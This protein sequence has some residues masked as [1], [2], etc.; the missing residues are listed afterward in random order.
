M[1]DLKNSYANRNLLLQV[2]TVSLMVHYGFIPEYFPWQFVTTLFTSVFLI[3]KPTNLFLPVISVIVTLADYIF[4]YPELS[5]HAVIQFF[6]CLGI[7]L[8]VVRSVL[9]FKTSFYTAEQKTAL[10]RL[11]VFLIYFFSGFHKLNYGFLDWDQSCV[12]ELN[13]QITYF[14]GVGEATLPKWIVRIMQLATLFVELIVPFGLLWRRT[15]KLSV[16]LLF[17]LHAYLFIAGF[18]H[19]A[20]VS[21]VLLPAC[22]IDFR[23]VAPLQTFK[24]KLRSYVFIA[25]LA[26]LV[27]FFGCHFFG[28]RYSADKLSVFFFICC[29]IYFIAFITAVDLFRNY[30]PAAFSYKKILDLKVLF[31]VLFIFLWGMEPYYGLSNR[32]NMSM[33]SNLITMKGRDNHLLMKSKYTKLIP[34]EE[35]CLQLLEV[36]PNLIRCFGRDYRY[37]YYPVITF[38][39]RTNECLRTIQE[40]VYVKFIYKSD[41]IS[42]SDLRKSV[43]SAS[44]WYDRYFYYRPTPVKGYGICVW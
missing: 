43:W 23:S 32:A 8:L 1:A 4:A 17:V 31:P 9:N 26:S 22:L 38:R 12:N 15:V 36:S 40:P 3:Y 10:L 30:T 14:S 44:H 20:S 5:N 39:K 29:G 2:F 13:R 25:A 21:L 11:I 35:D 24:I 33:Y 34:F 37:Y 27:C 41:T 42:I 19:F 28:L 6:I 16:F 7:M 18:A